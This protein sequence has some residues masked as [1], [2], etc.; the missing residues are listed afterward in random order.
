MKKLLVI[1]IILTVCLSGCFNNGSVTNHSPSTSF[2]FDGTQNFTNVID[3]EM[4]LIEVY[5][6]DVKTPFSRDNQVEA[7]KDI[8]TIKFDK[9]MVSG[10]GAPNLYSAPYSLGDNQTI[11]IMMMRSTLMASFLEPN[12]LSEY[13]FFGYV[14]N[15]IE[16]RIVNNT[17]ELNSKRDNDAVKL[18]FGL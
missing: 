18:V 2:I 12:D 4:K 3:N 7:F 16:W 9:E 15:S 11:S 10:T 6:N 13:E 8:Y 14:Q 5:I 1:L 17:L